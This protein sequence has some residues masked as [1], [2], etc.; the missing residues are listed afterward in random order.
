MDLARR[1]EFQVVPILKVE[2][3]FKSFGATQALIDAS[4]DLFAGEVH[5]LL[6]ENGAGKSTLA[7][8]VAGLI[9][10]DSGTISIDGAPVSINSTKDARQHGI[11]IVF[12]ELSLAPDLSIVDNL[13]L[14]AESHP[15]PYNLLR[16]RDEIELSRSTLNQLELEVD[17][18]QTVSELSI[19]EKQMLEIAK[20]L[21]QQPRI[22]IMDEPTSTLTEKEKSHLFRVIKKLQDNGVAIL[23]VTHHLREVFQIGSRV[24]A[25]RDG[26]LKVT[27]EVTTDVTEAHLLEMLTGR[28]LSNTVERQT[29]SSKETLLQIEDITTSEEECKNVSLFVRSGEVVGVYGVV[30][31]GREQ[32][33]Q[34]IVGLSRPTSGAMKIDGREYAPGNPSSARSKGVGYLP[35]DRKE[36]GILSERPIRENLNLSRLA[37]LAKLGVINDEQDKKDALDLLRELR[38]HYGSMDYPIT[39]LS[40]GNQQKV[41]FGRAIAHKPRLLVMEDPTSGIDMGAKF[42]LYEILRD[43]AKNGLSFLLLSS[44]LAET[45]VLCDRVYTMYQGSLV[46]EFE[47]PSLTDEEEVL[48]HVLGRGKD[49]SVSQQVT[50]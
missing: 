47:S 25:M 21:L 7:K 32:L 5:I 20:A 41:L 14:G 18:S 9:T 17:P 48:S 15:R 40:G 28:E 35:M 13:F 8:I 45:L 11:A 27:T 26:G 6:G 19:A 24:S 16:R 34:L 36:R 4:I 31:C 3:L 22:L 43:L 29:H 30:G 38:V 46:K 2:R 23:Y 49:L 42:D 12:Q 50:N 44:D 33:G 10:G 1:D 37:S 39:S